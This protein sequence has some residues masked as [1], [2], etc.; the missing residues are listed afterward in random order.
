MV[1]PPKTDDEQSKAEEDKKVY[2]G[3]FVQLESVT[4]NKSERVQVKTQ[5]E[6]IEKDGRRRGAWRDA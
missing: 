4:R 1:R 6:D 2:E 5:R 3:S